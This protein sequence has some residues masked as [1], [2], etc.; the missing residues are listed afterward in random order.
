MLHLYTGRL[1][2]HCISSLEATLPLNVSASA[3]LAGHGSTPAVFLLKVEMRNYCRKGYSKAAWQILTSTYVHIGLTVSCGGTYK[4]P[5][6]SC[7]PKS[8][9][10]KH[11]L[12][13]MP[14]SNLHLFLHGNDTSQLH[15]QLKTEQGPEV[16][17]P[18]LVWKNFPIDQK[19]VVL[20]FTGF[21][22]TK[23][24]K[25]LRFSWQFYVTTD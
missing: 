10:L 15:C 5:N 8:K 14:L 1:G 7:Y 11:H 12:Q 4:T 9:C 6:I 18:F 3:F 21:H 20:T 13:F 24:V 17:R 2:C 16:V 23:E 22:Q 25:N 19:G